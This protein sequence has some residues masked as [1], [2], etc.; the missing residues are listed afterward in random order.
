MKTSGLIEVILYANDMQAQVEFYRDV[1]G[2][3]VNFPDGISDYSQEHWVTF[4]TGQCL[5]ALHSG[6]TRR[7]GE[8]LPKIVFGVEDLQA[9][10]EFLLQKG[11]KIGPVRT[12]GLNIAV[13]DGFDPEGNPFSIEARGL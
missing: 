5:L 3:E 4:D 2:L 1:I 7:I 12:V 13:C 10:R 11:V 6:G 8:G 9:A